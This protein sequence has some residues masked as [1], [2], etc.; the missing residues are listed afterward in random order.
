MKA[1][2]HHRRG[3]SGQVTE[4]GLRVYLEMLSIAHTMVFP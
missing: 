2:A 3:V 4:K 1:F